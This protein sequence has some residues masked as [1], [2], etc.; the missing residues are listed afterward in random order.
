MK[1]CLSLAHAV[2][3]WSSM[4]FGTGHP[5]AELKA[6]QICFPFVFTELF[7]ELKEA[8]ATEFTGVLPRRRNGDLHMR[9]AGRRGGKWA[10]STHPSSE[11]S[12]SLS[13]D[14]ALAGGQS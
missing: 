1:E 13:S 2:Q 14:S 6:E 11:M 10:L 8:F 3:R 4:H 12:E 5:F 9:S 7:R